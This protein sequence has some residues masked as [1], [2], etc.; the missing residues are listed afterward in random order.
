MSKSLVVYQNMFLY[1][2]VSTHQ[3]TNHQYQ[4][5]RSSSSPTIGRRGR[6]PMLRMT[7]EARPLL[8]PGPP[9]LLTAVLLH[10][11]PGL[12]RP[13]LSL[14]THSLVQTSTLNSS[15]LETRRVRVAWPR[16][17]LPA[18]LVSESHHH[19]AGNQAVSARPWTLGDSW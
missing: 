6:C 3:L 16:P 13:L 15:R 12:H 10:D 1:N 4:L 19:P 11:H 17:A 2:W 18:L 8:L 7:W 9:G 14:G 5:R